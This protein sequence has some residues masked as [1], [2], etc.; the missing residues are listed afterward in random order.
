MISSTIICS[1]EKIDLYTLGYTWARG[2]MMHVVKPCVVTYAV[3]RLYHPP[4]RSKNERRWPMCALGGLPKEGK[5][6]NGFFT[7]VSF[8]RAL[9]QHC[10]HPFYKTSPPHGGRE[11]RLLFPSLDQERRRRQIASSSSSSPF[12]SSLLHAC[13]A[14]Q[15]DARASIIAASAR[16]G[17]GR[18]PH[19][20][21]LFV[22]QHV[23]LHKTLL[24][25][26]RTLG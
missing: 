1:Q 7:W 8:R 4:S 17:R 21:A 10:Y 19:L 24:C 26:Y 16:V 22:L 15:G 12:P 14:D 6:F 18:Q 20:L 2:G 25:T 23:Y 3:F 11:R 9:L 5:C 13:N